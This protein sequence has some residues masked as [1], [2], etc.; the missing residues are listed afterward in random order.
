[1]V[2][3]TNVS[4]RAG[5]MVAQDGDAVGLDINTYDKREVFIADAKADLTELDQR[6]NELSGKVT[7]ASAAVKAAAQPKIDELRKQRVTL[8]Q[9]LETL[10]SAKEA[11]WNVLKADYQKADSQMKLSL[12]ESWKWVQD[13]TG[14]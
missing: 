5:F 7:T 1:V 2:A 9:K 11:D 8:D 4:Q 6:I 3:W 10:K 12:H 13:N 14:S